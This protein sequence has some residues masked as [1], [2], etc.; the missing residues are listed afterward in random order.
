[1]YRILIVVLIASPALRDRQ[2]LGRLTDWIIG[3]HHCI[4]LLDRITDQI[5]GSDHGSDLSQK[6]VI[7]K[8][9]IK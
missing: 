2:N 8:V 3:S 7:I 4:E 1:M 6:N 9:I 5:I